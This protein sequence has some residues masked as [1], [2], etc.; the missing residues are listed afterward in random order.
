MDTRDELE[1][2]DGAGEDVDGDCP[3][4]MRGVLVMTMVMISPSQRE[5]SPAE[6]FRQSPRLVS[7]RFR[8]VA[9]EFRPRR[10]LVIFSSSKDFISQK[11]DM[12]G[13]PGGPRGRGRAQGGR[14]RP[15]PSWAGCGPPGELLALSIFYIF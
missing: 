6:Q 13:P 9:A 4:P 7:P 2:G 10:W 15:S 8:L 14:A 5:V 12:G 11:M 1:F 3:L